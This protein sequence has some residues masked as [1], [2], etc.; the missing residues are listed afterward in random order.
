LDVDHAEGRV[1]QEDDLVRQEGNV[2]RERRDVTRRGPDA[3]LQGLTEIPLIG[4]MHEKGKQPSE[5]ISAIARLGG[6]LSLAPDCSQQN[7]EAPL[8]RGGSALELAN[9]MGQSFHL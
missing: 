1:Q 4:G 9:G 6:N 5:R 7:V 2:I 8:A 3:R